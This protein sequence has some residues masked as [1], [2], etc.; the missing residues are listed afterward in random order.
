MRPGLSCRETR[1]DPGARK[2]SASELRVF[3]PKKKDSAPVPVLEADFGDRFHEAFRRGFRR[4]AHYSRLNNLGPPRRE[5]V[6]SAPSPA[7]ND[8]L[9]LV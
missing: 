5:S 6:L 3:S 2:D 8:Q 9:T 7:L 4:L 1:A